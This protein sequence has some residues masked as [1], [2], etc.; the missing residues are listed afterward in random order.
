[1]E[2]I[3][4]CPR[5]KKQSLHPEFPDKYEVWLKCTECGFFLG[6]SDYDWHHIANSPNINDKIR[7]KAM[8][9]E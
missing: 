9:E 3:Y 2:R 6:M 4:S 7:K 8:K 5:C 1:M